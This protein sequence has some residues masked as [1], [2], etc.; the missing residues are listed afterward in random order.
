MSESVDDVEDGFSECQG[1]KRSSWAVA[2]VHN[3]VMSADVNAF[4]M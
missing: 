3:E 2:A 1:Y 4:E